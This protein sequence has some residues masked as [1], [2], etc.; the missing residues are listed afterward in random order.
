M[1]PK[2]SG[3]KSFDG[4]R[5]A[6]LAMADTAGSITAAAATL[7]MKADMTPATVIRG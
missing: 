1:A 7:F 3:M 2:D 5:F 4:D 6:C